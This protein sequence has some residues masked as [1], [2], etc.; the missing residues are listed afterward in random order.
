LLTAVQAVP[1]K[2]PFVMEIVEANGV[3]TMDFDPDTGKPIRDPNANAA[4]PTVN[5]PSTT[6]S[7]PSG[8]GANAPAGDPGK[9]LEDFPIEFDGNP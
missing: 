3:R 7:V 5:V 2:P 1:P 8:K 6:G 4:G 9:M